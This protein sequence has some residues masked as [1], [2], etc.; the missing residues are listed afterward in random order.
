MKS[1]FVAAGLIALSS[2]ASAMQVMDDQ[3]L[4][5]QTGQDG[6]T[7]KV[8]VSK[9]TF[10]QVALIDT[11]GMTGAANSAALVMASNTSGGSIG[12]NFLDGAGAAVN[13]L[14]TTTIDSDAGNSGAFANFNLAFSELKTIKVDPFSVYLAPT[15]NNSRTIG[16]VGSVFGTGTSL[17]PGVSKLVQIGSGPEGLNINFKDAL[18]INLQLG[19]TPQ[20]HMFRFSGALQSINIPKIQVFS[21]NANSTTSSLSLDAKFSATNTS[22]FGLDGFFVDV[23]SGGLQFGN[24][25]TTNK[26][27]VELNNVVAGVANAQDPNTFNNLKNGSMGNFGIVGATV[28]NLK[29]NVR[30]M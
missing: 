28:S 6:I 12:V 29:M 1:I 22:G 18:G 8:G 10:D 16:S 3:D 27:N 13:N 24:D 19:S 7:L 21:K 15:L 9:I 14:V 23:A 4:A 25:G 11:N 17:R 26:F 5:S 2:L 30:G 20:G